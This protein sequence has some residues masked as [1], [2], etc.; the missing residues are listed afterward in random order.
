MSRHAKPSESIHS[1]AIREPLSIVTASDRI[2]SIPRG[3]V[4]PRVAAHDLPHTYVTPSSA[5]SSVAK[6]KKSSCCA[7]V[8]ESQPLHHV[9]KHTRS[10]V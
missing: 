9:S 2:T 3:T 10:E 7:S 1:H 6:R 4:P 5:C 8:Q